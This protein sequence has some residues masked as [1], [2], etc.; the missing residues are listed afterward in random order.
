MR[1]QSLEPPDESTDAADEFEVAEG[2]PVSRPG[3]L[4]TLGR[5]RLLCGNALDS[6]AYDALLAG[7]KAAAVFT[8]PP[9]NV[10]VK[11]M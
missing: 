8:D 4:W 5:H 7:E 9:Y 6:C 3:D 2:P 11:A 1:I 10:R